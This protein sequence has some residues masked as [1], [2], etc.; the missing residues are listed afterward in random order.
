MLPES[1]PGCQARFCNSPASPP[2]RGPGQTPDPPRIPTARAH[3]ACAAC[4]VDSPERL[5]GWL[6]CPG[7]PR[8]RQTP[9]PPRPK[10]S[11]SQQPEREAGGR[12]GGGRAVRGAS[13]RAPAA[14]TAPGGCSCLSNAGGQ[15]GQRRAYLTCGNSRHGMAWHGI[16]Q[17]GRAGGVAWRAPVA[18]SCQ[19]GR[20]PGSP[21]LVTA[22]A[23][24][25][26]A[27]GRRA[28]GTDRNAEAAPP[29]GG[30]ICA[31]HRLPSER[32]KGAEARER[33]RRERGG[34]ERESEASR[35]TCR[36]FLLQ[37]GGME[38]LA[39][40]PSRAFPLRLSKLE[41]QGL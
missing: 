39:R 25:A 34:G 28:T 38:L 2:N 24:Q 23:S 29:A 27:R 9:L 15:G 22:S 37:R 1:G 16:R 4:H 21:C 36:S 20:S 40:D 18:P 17:P 26:A 14:A 41:G 19:P 32:R 8:P 13:A 33:E 7:S 10:V 11:S 30:R 5:A 3:L 31:R 12:E 6:P 35:A